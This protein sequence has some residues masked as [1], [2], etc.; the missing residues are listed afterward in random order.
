MNRLNLCFSAE[1]VSITTERWPSGLMDTY[2]DGD[3]VPGSGRV[4]IT[5]NS[6]GFVMK[7]ARAGYVYCI[8]DIWE[9]G[10]V[11]YGSLVK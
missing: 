7:E 3:E 11:E 1:L 6:E 9:N 10:T 4:T 2:Q 5:K 8:T